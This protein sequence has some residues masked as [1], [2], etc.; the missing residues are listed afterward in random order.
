[1]KLIDAFL[2]LRIHVALLFFLLLLQKLDGLRYVELSAKIL[3]A[4]SFTALTLSIY[5]FNK[6]TGMKEDRIN[7][8]KDTVAKKNKIALSALGAILFFIPLVYL[9]TINK[10]LALLY[11]GAGV[12]GFFYSFEVRIFSLQLP[13]KRILFVKN[14]ASAFGWSATIMLIPFILGN[15][16]TPDTSGI[17]L[18]LFLTILSVEI[19]WDIKDIKG[20]KE[21]KIKTIPNTYGIAI[22][23]KMVWSLLFFVL[24]MMIAFRNSPTYF[25]GIVLMAIAT[26]LVKEKSQLFFYHAIVFVW[27][28]LLVLEVF[29][30]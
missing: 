29:I 24:I 12:L 11:L 22:A 14:V 27:I 2:K 5:I 7:N 16:W 23:K 18:I 28:A 26:Y 19:L 13:L 6:V 10:N 17:W 4:L 15:A 20:D 9:G 25:I 8:K 30:I 21:N 3:I 1:M